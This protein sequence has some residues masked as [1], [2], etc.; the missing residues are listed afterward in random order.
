M[1][2]AIFRALASIG[3]MLLAVTANAQSYSGNFVLDKVGV[4]STSYSYLVLSSTT[5]FP[6]SCPYGALYVDLTTQQGRAQ[7]SLALT[8]LAR[9]GRLSRIDVSLSAGICYVTLIEVPR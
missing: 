3:F 2:Q 9:D 5:P 1:K 7:Y 4:Q 6:V 8:S